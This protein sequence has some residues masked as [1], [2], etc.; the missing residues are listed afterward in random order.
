MVRVA[1]LEL[2]GTVFLRNPSVP[3]RAP[4]PWPAK[5]MGQFMP[6]GS[7]RDLRLKG[8]IKGKI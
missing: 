8:K 7:V 6:F 3:D 1:R 5:K 2:Y 4:C